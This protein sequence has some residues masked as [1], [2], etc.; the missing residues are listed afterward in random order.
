MYEPSSFQK[1][2]LIFFH[3]DPRLKSDQLKRILF[4]KYRGVSNAFCIDFMADNRETHCGIISFNSENE[5]KAAY[6]HFITAEE[7]GELGAILHEIPGVQMKSSVRWFV[8]KTL[9]PNN[10]WIGIVIRGLSKNVTKEKLRAMLGDGVVHIESPRQI[11]GVFCTIVALRSIDHALHLVSKLNYNTQ[12]VCLHPSSHIL[13]RPELIKDIIY[14]TRRRPRSNSATPLPDKK[15]KLAEAMGK[16]LSSIVKASPGV[17][18]P[19]LV[20]TES[21]VLEDGEITE[22]G[23][24]RNSS[25]TQNETC[26]IIY[27]Y[28]GVYATRVGCFAHSGVFIKTRHVAPDVQDNAL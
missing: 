10:E 27:E 24:K 9:D 23:Q 13:K 16:L 20:T 7:R 21:G 19:P 22:T 18:T 28:P 8:N 17:S 3:L 26:H 5:A 6:K 14:P 25:K 11:Q 15:P 1:P 2:T 12:K 4:G